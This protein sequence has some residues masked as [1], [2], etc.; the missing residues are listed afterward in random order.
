[1]Y[2]TVYEATVLGRSTSEV[3]DQID[4]LENRIRAEL[5]KKRTVR[6]VVT[7]EAIAEDANGLRIVA[8][9]D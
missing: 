4:R 1:M 9:R 3:E 8:I 6:V 2:T 7:S 5:G